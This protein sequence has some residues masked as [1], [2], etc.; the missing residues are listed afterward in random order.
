MNIFTSAPLATCCGDAAKRS[1]AALER[2]CALRSFIRTTLR[3]TMPWHV[4]CF[5]THV[6]LRITTLDINKSSV[7][8]IMAF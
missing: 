7:L 4:M 2:C 3:L 1:A 6:M 8:F 5:N